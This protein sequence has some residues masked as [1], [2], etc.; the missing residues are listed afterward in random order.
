[1]VGKKREN[2]NPKERGGL[3]VWVLSEYVMTVYAIGGPLA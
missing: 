1:M 2:K 3:V